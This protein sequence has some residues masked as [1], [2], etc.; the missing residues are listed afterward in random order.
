MN[1]LKEFKDS[2]GLFWFDFMNFGSVLR[3]KEFSLK[4]TCA[5]MYILQ[6]ELRHI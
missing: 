6:V 2:D 5:A 3:G 1:L 4:F